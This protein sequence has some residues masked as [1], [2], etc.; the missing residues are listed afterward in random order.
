[1]ENSTLERVVAILV[2]D[3]GMNRALHLP[4]GIKLILG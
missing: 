3:T 2:E 4:N 1:M